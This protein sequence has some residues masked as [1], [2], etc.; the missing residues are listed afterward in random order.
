MW[1][2]Y[3]AEYEKKTH[4]QTKTVAVFWHFIY[5][6]QKLCFLNP[7]FFHSI[8]S[9]PPLKMSQNIAILSTAAPEFLLDCLSECKIIS[10]E[11]SKINHTK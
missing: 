11:V 1:L 9:K 2:D 7:S 3:F 5:P 4:L 8:D 6:L 10:Q